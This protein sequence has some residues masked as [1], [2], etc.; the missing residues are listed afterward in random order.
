MANKGRQLQAKGKITSIA[1]AV[2]SMTSLRDQLRILKERVAELEN[3]P[4][5]ID[6]LQK[7]VDQFIADEG[8]QIQ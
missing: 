7:T 8:K 1:T 3:M 4:D 6:D 5:R 2:E